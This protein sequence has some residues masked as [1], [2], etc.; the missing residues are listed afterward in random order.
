MSIT[1]KDANHE[2]GIPRLVP[3]DIPITDAMCVH[4][5]LVDARKTAERAIVTAQLLGTSQTDLIELAQEFSVLSV[6]VFN[7]GIFPRVADHRPVAYMI[8]STGRVC[9]VDDALLYE[10]GYCPACGV[11]Y[12][13]V[14]PRTV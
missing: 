10:S 9:P 14:M 5:I 3:E 12:N 1:E 2:L 8:S 6:I 7:E 4:A 13:T 11:T